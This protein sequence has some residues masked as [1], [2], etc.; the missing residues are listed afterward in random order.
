MTDTS[1]SSHA[2]SS[3]LAV[4]LDERRVVSVTG[5]DARNFL[6]T[7]LTADIKGMETG[8]AVLAALLSPQG[9][10]IVDM[11][12]FDASDD[13]PLF[14]IDCR[15]GMAGD[16]VERLT[17]YRLRAQVGIDLLETSIGVMVVL[18]ALPLASDEIY[19][20][21]D[22]RHAGLG[23]RLIGPQAL[24]AAATSA[25]PQGIPA[26]Y[27]TRRVA[28]GIPEGGKDFIFGDPFPHEILLDQVHGVDFKKGCYVGQEVVSRMEHRGN[29]R[30]RAVPVRFVNGF[31]VMTGCDVFAG[32]L[33][34]GKVGESHGGRAIALLRLDRLQDAY[35]AGL[36]LIA[37]GVECVVEKPDFITFDLP[38]RPA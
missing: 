30:T 32:E 4:A 37:G 22:P 29:A 13:E 16:L 28:L 15:I 10:V 36:P 6:N 25:Y 33:S 9:K 35:H 3:S 38:Q 31:G 17:R 7:L 5:R 1:F 19:A 2:P 26:D 23:T 8:E 27:H 11:L 21:A 12:V 18:G 34:L 14:L 20:F 24:L